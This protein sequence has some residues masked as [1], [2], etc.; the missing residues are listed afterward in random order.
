L[1]GGSGKDTRLFHQGQADT[2]AVAEAAVVHRVAM[3]Q[4]IGQSQMFPDPVRGAVV[5]LQS[6]TNVYNPDVTRRSL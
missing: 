3:G 5:L 6:V 2:R 4:L 1:D